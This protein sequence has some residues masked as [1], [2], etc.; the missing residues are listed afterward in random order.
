[1]RP[2]VA[3]ILFQNVSAIQLI[4]LDQIS[5]VTTLEYSTSIDSCCFANC[6]FFL[7]LNL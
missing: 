4:A 7:N 3:Y 6:L 2:C 5:V 1:M